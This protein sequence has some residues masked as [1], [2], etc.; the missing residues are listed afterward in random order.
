MTTDSTT[1]ALPPVMKLEDCQNLHTFLERS[2]DRSV[3]LDCSAVTRL[4]GLG[5]QMIQMAR[6]AWTANAIELSLVNPSDECVES[7]NTLGLGDLLKE[8][9]A[10]R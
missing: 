4:G 3:S 8:E 7:L 9:E 5:A 10:A 1:Y 6:I 2:A